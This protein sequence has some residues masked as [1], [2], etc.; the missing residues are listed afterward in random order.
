MRP[1]R[2]AAL[3]VTGAVVAAATS[4]EAPQPRSAILKLGAALASAELET[5]QWSSPLTRGLMS[6]MSALLS[7]L[8]RRAATLTSPLALPGHL[9][10]GSFTAGTWSSSN[11]TIHGLETL[12]PLAVSPDDETHL[13]ATARFDRL[14]TAMT[15]DAQAFGMAAKLRAEASVA[16][17][18][19]RLRWACAPL[20][21]AALQAAR[22]GAELAEALKLRIDAVEVSIEGPIELQAHESARGIGAPAV[23]WRWFNS[24]FARELRRTV[25]TRVAEEMYKTL[26]SALSEA[27]GSTDP[28]GLFE[29]D[30]AC[31]DTTAPDGEAATG[32]ED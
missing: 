7:P 29:T 10:S 25:E 31:G 2:L 16:N 28:L 13:N 20:R 12:G 22:G 26:A 5:I 6:L 14:Q 32:G 23:L 24:V 3:V 4:Q 9:D 8:L 21:R 17:V 30:E 18:T 15:L 27:G 1:L 19:I 11:L